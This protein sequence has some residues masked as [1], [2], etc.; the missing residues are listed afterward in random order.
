MRRQ[1]KR[2]EVTDLRRARA[3]CLTA[4]A[5]AL[6]AA[7][8]AQSGEPGSL[9]A[10]VV[11]GKVLWQETQ[12]AP[13]RGAEAA[14]MSSM[15]ADIAA[16]PGVSIGKTSSSLKQLA[17]RVLG[18]RYP[19]AAVALMSFEPPAARESRWEMTLSG[20]PTPETAKLL[21]TDA[22]Q[23]QIYQS[24]HTLAVLPHFPGGE[25]FVGARITT[26]PLGPNT[27]VSTIF[28]EVRAV[29][30]FDGLIFTIDDGLEA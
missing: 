3:S 4:V 27:A 28:C 22:Q 29:T 1:E 26:E 9:A 12:S 2:F 13:S 20:A 6:V 7:P 23:M 24:M 10:T 19:C 25:L 5:A 30:R 16:T 17:T 21:A 8:V 11:A 15:S 14:A 18:E